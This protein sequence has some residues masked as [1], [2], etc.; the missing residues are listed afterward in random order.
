MHRV[1]PVVVGASQGTRDEFWVLLRG[2]GVG[3]GVNWS[4]LGVLLDCYN[5]CSG[6]YCDGGEE[7]E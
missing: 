1:K 4:V 5:I 7:T 6:L 3:N 2:H